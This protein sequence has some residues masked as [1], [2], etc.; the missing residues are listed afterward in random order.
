[1]VNLFITCSTQWRSSGFGATGMDYSAVLSVLRMKG[2]SKKKWP[3]LFDDLRILEDCALATMR[4][5][6]KTS[7]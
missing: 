6:S 3:R 1:M 4:H 7:R 5:F 2:V